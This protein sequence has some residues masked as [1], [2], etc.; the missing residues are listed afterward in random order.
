MITTRMITTGMITTGMI[1]VC[2]RCHRDEPTIP[3]RSAVPALSRQTLG[4]DRSPIAAVLLGAGA[5]S[6][7][8]GDAHKLLADLHGT[9]LYRH[10]LRHVVEADIGPVVLVTGAVDLPV[11]DEYANRVITVHNPSWQSGQSTSLRRGIE[12]ARRLG[13]AAV[14]VGLADQPGVSSAAWRRLADTGADLAVAMY[15]GRR[16]HPV[17][18]GARHWD[19]LP[20]GGDFGARDLLAV[21]SH[22]VE[23][24]PC[25]GT[26]TDI[27]TAEDLA[28]WLRRSP[29]NSP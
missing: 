16:G 8:T 15:E 1:T 4:M 2:R 19:E 23:Q 14:A 22:D 9:P 3:H 13:V 6:R 7:F 5:G 28:T 20:E 17:R 21:H 29:T 27:D 24:I 12:E 10:A 25:P 18:I 11:P 26:A